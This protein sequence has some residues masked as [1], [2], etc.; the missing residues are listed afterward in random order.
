MHEIVIT[1]EQWQKKADP[2]SSRAYSAFSMLRLGY[3]NSNA[4]FFARDAT[5]EEIVSIDWLG[6]LAGIPDDIVPPEIWQKR[7]EDVIEMVNEWLLAE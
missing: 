5:T 6:Y 4:V 3:V 1:P 2:L 7:A